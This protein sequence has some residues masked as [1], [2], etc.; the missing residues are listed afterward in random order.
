MEK[1]QKKSG[2]EENK[3]RRYRST[4]G[5][6]TK[7]LDCKDTGRRAEKDMV[8]SIPCISVR[9][10]K[11]RFSSLVTFLAS[12]LHLP[13]SI[14]SHFRYLGGE[15]HA[16]QGRDCGLGKRGSSPQGCQSHCL[17]GQEAWV[18]DN[19]GWER[20]LRPATHTALLLGVGA[21][22][23]GL[24]QAVGH[25]SHSPGTRRQPRRVHTVPS[26]SSC[27]DGGQVQ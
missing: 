5:T 7:V 10:C 16:H 11:K 23:L 3:Y 18:T 20:S 27:R 15:Q 19:H 1:S 13:A 8:S 24:V 25:R 26:A 22:K 6:T 4:M 12:R 2:A 9:L 21:P 14:L 17:L